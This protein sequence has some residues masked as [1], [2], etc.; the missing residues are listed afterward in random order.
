MK[1]VLT[2]NTKY[3]MHMSFDKNLSIG[4]SHAEHGPHLRLGRT[5]IKAKK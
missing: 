4:Q 3:I 1:N 5:Q 2:P